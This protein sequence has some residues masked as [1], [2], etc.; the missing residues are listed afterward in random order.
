MTW[1]V[2]NK[3]GDRLVQ[4]A[5]NSMQWQFIDEKWPNFAQESRNIHLGLAIDVINMFAKKCSTWN[6]WPMVLLNYNL[7]LW[8]TT[9]KHFVMLSLII[10]N[11]ESMTSEN[12]DT[13]LE[14][15]LEE[16]KLL[17]HNGVEVQDATDYNGSSH[18]MLKAIL[19]W[20]IQD[21]HVC[22]IMVG[23]VTKGYHACPICVPTTLY[24][25]SN[26]LSKHVYCN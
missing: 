1:H 3:S 5:T 14:P 7:P 2:S 9:K 17:W 25:Q 24:H 6:T 18:F 8:L 12:M 11:E 16:I 13:F 10:P 4:H 21:F 20:C 19:M 15:L 26:V 23:R 22:G